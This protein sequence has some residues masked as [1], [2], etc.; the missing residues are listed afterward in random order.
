MSLCIKLFA[1]ALVEHFRVCVESVFCFVF[2]CLFFSLHGNSEAKG[3]ACVHI[4][5]VLCVS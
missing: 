2:V 3:L 4:E 1:Y 5:P